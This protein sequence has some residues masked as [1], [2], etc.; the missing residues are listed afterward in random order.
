MTTMAIVE[1]S[2]TTMIIVEAGDWCMV[3]YA[4]CKSLIILR[5]KLT[6]E[7]TLEHGYW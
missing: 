1:I 5:A 3:I 6:T 7:M 2:M 4:P